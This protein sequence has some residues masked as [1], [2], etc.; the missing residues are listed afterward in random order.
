MSEKRVERDFLGEVEVPASAYYGSFTARAL[1][2]YF[3][4]TQVCPKGIKVTKAINL[5]N[6]RIRKRSGG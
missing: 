5:T 4:C 2:N 6:A 3:K 1:R